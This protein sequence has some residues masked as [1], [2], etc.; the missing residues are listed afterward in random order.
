MSQTM[1]TNSK[2]GAAILKQNCLFKN[3]SVFDMVYFSDFKRHKHPDF[4]N[5]KNVLRIQC[6]INANLKFTR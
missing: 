5:T 6:N 1:G 4:Q 2:H 3:S